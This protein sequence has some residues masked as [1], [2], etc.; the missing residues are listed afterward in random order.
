MKLEFNL[1]QYNLIFH[2]NHYKGQWHCFQRDEYNAYFN[3]GS[4]NTVGSGDSPEEAYKSYSCKHLHKRLHKE[5][6]NLNF[7]L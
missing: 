5:V 4:D 3:G 1:K 2:Y 7:K 6:K